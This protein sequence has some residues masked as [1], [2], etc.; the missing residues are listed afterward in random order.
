[1][2]RGKRQ[3]PG[4]GRAGHNSG[5]PSHDDVR[6]ALAIEMIFEEEAKKLREKHKRARKK[7]EGMGVRLDDLGDLKSMRDMTGNEIE[8]LFKRRWHLAGAIHPDKYEQLDIFAAKPSAPEKRAANYTM[9]LLAGLQGKELDIPLM[10]VGDDRD[11][12]IQGHNEG[13]ERRE[14]AKLDILAEALDPVNEGKVTDGT[15]ATVGARAA[16]DFASDNG[17]DPLVVDGKTY[18]NMRQA[19]AARKRLEEKAA[20][21]PAVAPVAEED[22]DGEKVAANVGEQVDATPKPKA[23]VSRPVWDD[24]NL[25]HEEWTGPQKMEFKR[26]FDSQPSEFT[27]A[28]THD[29]AE[30]YF[31]VLRE[32]QEAAFGAPPAAGPDLSEEAIAAGAKALAENGFVPK[33]SQ[34]QKRG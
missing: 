28:T 25:D 31:K 27:L 14:R 23:V 20:G 10:V 34:R 4:I 16:Q 26:W 6:T 11:Q 3:S 5:L 33:K 15:T 7:I 17:G 18:P 21:E 29:G 22:G 19:N 2:A 8:D 12:M 24:W 13:R 1:M 9:G 32:E 30:A